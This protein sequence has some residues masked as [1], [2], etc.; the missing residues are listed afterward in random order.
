[1]R[2]IQ[3]SILSTA[4]LYEDLR[5]LI[6]GELE[7]KLF[8]NEYKTIFKE[9]KKLYLQRQDIDPVVMLGSLGNAYT[10]SI[11]ELSNPSFV[12]TNLEQY[13]KIQVYIY[14]MTRFQHLIL[15]QIKT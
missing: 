5:Y 2:E 3:K 12:K 8:D 7:D 4:I 1:M 10:D 9:M 15:K 6:F 11:A 13:I 14:L